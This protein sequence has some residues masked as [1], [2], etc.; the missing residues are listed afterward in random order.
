MPKG[1]IQSIA[2]LVL[3]VLAYTLYQDA[4]AGLILCGL[5]NVCVSN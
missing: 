3:A 1:V 2:C 5:A 4:T